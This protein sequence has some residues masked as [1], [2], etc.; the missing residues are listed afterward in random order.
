MRWSSTLSRE[1]AGIRST[2]VLIMKV[3]ISLRSKRRDMIIVQY[4][5][6]EW[7]SIIVRKV[8]TVSKY[9]RT[10]PWLMLQDQ[11]Q[12]EI[13]SVAIFWYTDSHDESKISQI[14]VF[15]RASRAS[16]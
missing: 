9:D 16:L 3:S 4:N 7:Y 14:F 2:F 6:I 8:R 15:Q 10:S 11:N 1:L 13:G 12:P 5:V